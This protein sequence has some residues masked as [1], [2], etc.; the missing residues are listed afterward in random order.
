MTRRS[1]RNAGP[2]GGPRRRRLPEPYE[3]LVRE[4]ERAGW[5]TE[6]AKDGV[7]CY[8]PDGSRPLTVHGTNRRRNWL[9]RNVRAQFRRAGLDV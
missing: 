1:T 2:S 8:P 6:D 5:R 7:T 3:S 4:A 9:D